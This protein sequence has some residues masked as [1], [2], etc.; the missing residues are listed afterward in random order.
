MYFDRLGWTH[1]D[2]I[3]N[4]APQVA[5]FIQEFFVKPTR[6]LFGVPPAEKA[7]STSPILNKETH[8]MPLSDF[9]R[10]KVFHKLEKLLEEMGAENG[11]ACL[12]RTICE[13]HELPFDSGRFGLFGEVLALILG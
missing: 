7:K 8:K 6:D 1:E 11:K 13:I 9:H 12:L 3:Y 2:S 4:S 5:K 10:L